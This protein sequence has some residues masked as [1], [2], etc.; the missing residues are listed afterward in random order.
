[1]SRR[2]DLTGQRFGR[3]VITRFVGTDKH[4]NHRYEYVCDC[5]NTGTV[6]DSNLRSGQ[7]KSCGCLKRDLTI[8]RSTKHGLS[9]GNRGRTRLYNIWLKMRARCLNPSDP[10]YPYYGGRGITICPE[11]NDFA[12]FHAWAYANGYRDDLTLDRIDND[13]PYSPDNCRWVP[14]K[15]QARN[16]RNNR[17]LTFRGETKSVVEWAEEVGIPAHTLR[18]RLHRGWPVERALTTPIDVKKK[19]VKE[20]V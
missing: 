3:L 8:A 17:L 7:V 4:W 15:R 9:G 11:W 1:M 18:Q 12:A 16:R 14:A 5:G 2:I 13:G 10:N 20:A 6:L 19:R